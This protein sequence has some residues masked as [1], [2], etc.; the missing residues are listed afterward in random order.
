VT[1]AR[2]PALAV[3]FCPSAPLLMPE[4]EGRADADTTVLRSA[5]ADAVAAMLAVRPEVVVVVGG[6]A[7]PGERYGAG[8]AGDLRGFGVDLQP[9]FDGRTRPGGRRVPLPHTMGARLLDDAGYAGTRVGVGSADL[10]QL[11]LGLPGPL[12]VLVMGDGSAR[13]SVKA[14]GYL[15]DAAAP[16]DAAVARALA[17]GDAAALADLD[18]VEGRRLLAAGVPAWRAVGAALAG[19]PIHGRLHLDAAPF[20]V[21][22]LVADWE[23]G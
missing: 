14:P 1:A 21:G 11:L 18:P 20:G 16:F 2:R 9:P 3:A 17:G 15:D 7:G 19:R 5:C 8:D 12:G 4:V 10:G 23:V 6:G 13:R 22:Y